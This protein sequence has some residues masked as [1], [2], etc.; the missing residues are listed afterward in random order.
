M[1]YVTEKALRG[2]NSVQDS[3]SWPSGS[4]KEQY[5]GKFILK[6]NIHKN[7]HMQTV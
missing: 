7:T 6:M 1:L 2:K 5:T 4:Q 3:H